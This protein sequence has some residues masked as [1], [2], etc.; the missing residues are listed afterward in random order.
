MKIEPRPER[1]SKNPVPL[2]LM[3][4]TLVSCLALL[5]LVG[6]GESE[7]SSK[8]DESLVDT[9]PAITFMRTLESGHEIVFIDSAEAGARSDSASFELRFSANSK[10]SLREYSY[11]I[12]IT[13]GTYS[14]R[15]DEVTLII[16]E[17]N[18]FEETKNRWP[19]LTLSI[20]G[21]QFLL[22]RNDG[23]RSFKEHNNVYPEAV[24]RI[25]PL[26]AKIPH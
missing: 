8:R 21:D 10:L 13:P 20:E 24:E 3:K 19:T 15:G 11:S 9:S 1:A 16:D 23:L 26:R 12:D 25:F 7:T 5:A 4:S 14:I 17:R 22:S 2:V 18:V 6:C